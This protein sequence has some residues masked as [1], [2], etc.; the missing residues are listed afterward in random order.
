MEDIK[1]FVIGSLGAVDQRTA[2][3]GY[4]SAIGLHLVIGLY[5]LGRHVEAD[6]N[7]VALSQL[8][9]NR[10]LVYYDITLFKIVGMNNS[11]VFPKVTVHSRAG[12]IESTTNE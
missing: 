5:H 6:C 3:D 12:A 1:I 7:L 9:A 4:S 8:S 11:F 10:T 2:L